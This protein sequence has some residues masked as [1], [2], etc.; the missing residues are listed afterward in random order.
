MIF[1]PMY[2]VIVGPAMLLA[3]WAQFSVKSAYHKGS[4]IAGRN[5]L[6]GADVARQILRVNGVAGVE[7][8]QVPGVM[9][10]HYDPKHKVLRLSPDVYHGR[11]LAAQGIAAHEVGHALQDAQQYAPL[12]VRNG[13]VPLATTGSSLSM[14]CIV[15]GI[16]LT[17]AQ[18]IWVGIILFSAIVV[19]QLVNLPVEFD[20]SRRARL[21]LVDNGLISVE[22]DRVVGKVLNAAAMTYVA[23]TITALLTLV[24]YIMAARRS[25]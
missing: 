13:I 8:E 12:V 19:F 18:L 22:E 24:Y 4:R 25:S 15:A 14:I 5:G 10:D 1:D 9:T 2:F 20:A 21:A 6:T 17:W 11:S 7:I 16:L 3:L 23:A